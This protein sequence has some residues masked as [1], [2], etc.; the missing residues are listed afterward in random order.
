MRIIS[1]YYDNIPQTVLDAQ[2]A[3]VSR[4]MAPGDSFEQVLTTSHGGELDTQMSH[5]DLNETVLFLDIDCIPLRRAAVGTADAVAK[6]GALYGLYGQCGSRGDPKLSFVI[7]AAL[8]L[9]GATYR[10]MGCPTFQAG[11]TWDVAGWVTHEA[12]AH[13]VPITFEYPVG[14]V[15]QAP[16][17]YDAF[18]GLGT[19]YGRKIPLFFHQFMV[20]I[21]DNAEKF[22]AKCEEVLNDA[23]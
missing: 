7:P 5:I 20:R 12:R 17:S 16:W 6:G 10:R 2:A 22:V 11:P 1:T 13:S 3:V 18:T 19:T 9:S 15:S 8:A 4:C 21:G 14:C 23:I